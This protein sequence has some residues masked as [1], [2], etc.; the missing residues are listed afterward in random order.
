MVSVVISNLIG[1]FI[2]PLLFARMYLPAVGAFQD[3]IP[4]EAL[5]NLSPLYRSVMMQTGLSVFVPL[6]VGQVVRALF[7][8]TVSKYVVKWKLGKV[9]QV[10]LLLLVWLVFSHRLHALQRP[11]GFRPFYTD[12]TG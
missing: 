2:T 12:R 1:P 10:M 8:E 6:A 4:T 7:T 3:W 11:R 9:G 5:D